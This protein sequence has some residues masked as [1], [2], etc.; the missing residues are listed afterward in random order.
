MPSSPPHADVRRSRVIAS[1]V[2][3]VLG[4]AGAGFVLATTCLPLSHDAVPR[5]APDAG[6]SDPDSGPSDASVPPHRVT[7]W[8][9]SRG[10]C[11]L[12]DGTLECCG[13]GALDGLRVPDVNGVWMGFPRDLCYTKT[14]GGG[15]CL[16]YAETKEIPSE[17]TAVTAVVGPEYGMCV[18]T[19]AGAVECLSDGA[20]SVVMQG[21]NGLDASLFSLFALASGDIWCWGQ[22]PF[23]ICV[24]PPAHKLTDVG[25]IV[26]IETSLAGHVCGLRRGGAVLCWGGN[27]IAHY[28]AGVDQVATRPRYVNGIA[29]ITWLRRVGHAAFCGG[30][31][32]PSDTLQCWGLGQAPL[33]ELPRDAVVAHERGFFDGEAFRLERPVVDVAGSETLGCS[34][35]T[36]GTETC[37][38]NIEPD[39]LHCGA[40]LLPH[41]F[42]EWLDTLFE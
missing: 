17:T 29:P 8:V 25:D 4:L 3:S 7:L 28:P 5:D 14:A 26:A 37:V 34:I 24:G 40:R 19:I 27:V 13:R 31:D 11:R 10:R 21:A 41:L 33:L 12:V 16:V 42:D 35:G 36:D 22:D 18:L 15:A 1:I 6:R 20:W 38:T 30:G 23:E 32:G 39:R 2:V 9:G